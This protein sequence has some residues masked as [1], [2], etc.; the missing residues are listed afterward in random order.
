[1]TT[2]KK[3]YNIMYKKK[4]DEEYRYGFRRSPKGVLSCRACGA[5][6]FRGRWSLAPAE[7]VHRRV[8]A[9]EGVKPTYC[10]AC[11]K[12]RE[13]YWQG[14]VEISGIDSQD[15]P[16]ILRLIRNEEA[17]ARIKNPL[18]R[19]MA[20]AVDTTGMRVETTTEKFAQRLGRALKKARG[21]EVTYKWS[22]RNKFARVIW[23]KSSLMVAETKP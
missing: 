18:E 16:E 1:M 15:K 5:I 7:A 6:Y 23:Q 14:V 10:P 13:G 9:G 8:A 19:V 4:G 2:T 17:K 12:I 21:G 11:L 3:P 20:I 22:E